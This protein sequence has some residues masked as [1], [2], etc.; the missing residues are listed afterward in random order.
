MGADTMK[1][2]IDKAWLT[3]MTPVVVGFDVVVEELVWSISPRMLTWLWRWRG[4]SFD[5]DADV[6]VEL[7]L[8]LMGWVG[9]LSTLSFSLPP[10]LLTSTPLSKEASE[11]SLSDARKAPI[12]SLRF[13][14]LCGDQWTG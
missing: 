10:P 13:E 2:V 12:N 11:S 7:V 6:A 14:F 3:C 4:P 1:V 8:A 5:S 9:P